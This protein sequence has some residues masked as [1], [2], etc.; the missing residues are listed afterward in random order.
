MTLI[1]QINKFIIMFK[2]IG[3]DRV[4]APKQL[5]TFAM[6][7]SLTLPAVCGSAPSDFVMPE[8]DEAKIDSILL[9]VE[10][11][12][13]ETALG[14]ISKSWDEHLGEIEVEAE[15]VRKSFWM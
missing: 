7:L 11:D 8:F 14:K 10:F 2:S 6:G 12:K 5:L 4:A 15:A 13:F 3:L 1:P 9:R